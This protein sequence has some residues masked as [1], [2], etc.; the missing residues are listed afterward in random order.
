MIVEISKAILLSQ[1]RVVKAECMRVSSAQHEAL[2][3]LLCRISIREMSGLVC[4]SRKNYMGVAVS[5]AAASFRR[6]GFWTSPF[7][8]L[9]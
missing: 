7:T 5:D 8:T 9:S 2:H 3:S 6:R 1:A 4:P